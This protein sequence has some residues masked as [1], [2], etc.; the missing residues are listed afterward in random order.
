MVRLKS[1][2]LICQVLNGAIG[3]DYNS[4]G[5]QVSSRDI[6]SKLMEIVAENHGVYGMSKDCRVMYFDPSSG[7]LCVRTNRDFE[8]ELHL[9]LTCL[10]SLKGSTPTIVRCLRTTGSVRTCVVALWEVFA[11]YVEANAGG[12]GRG[13]D[14][15]HQ[16]G[17]L[18]ALEAEKRRYLDEIRA[19]FNVET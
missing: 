4:V 17:D 5:M 15:A 1:R 12:T 6:H 9:A 18:E 16:D 11:G 19:S 13:G 8:N 10:S 7:M 3:S 2:Y 14:S